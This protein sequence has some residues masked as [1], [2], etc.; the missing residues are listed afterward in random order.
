M[1]I[2]LNWIKDFVD[3]GPK[4]NPDKLSELITTRTAEVEGYEDLADSFKN[5]VVGRIKSIKAHPDADKLTVT[6]TSIGSKTLQVICGASNI[7]EGMFAPV[8]LS[9]AM[10]KWHGEGEP[11]APFPLRHD[12]AHG[13]GDA[14]HADE[15]LRADVG[16]DDGAPDGVPRQAFAGQKVP[17]RIASFPAGDPETQG[18]VGHEVDREHEKVEL[19]RHSGVHP[20]WGRRAPI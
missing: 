10:V 20:A 18:N 8:A 4:T 2:S 14:N 15:V 11:V 1:K 3:L 7:F 19:V 6:E 13:V 9:G 16:S 5:I 17:A 12:K